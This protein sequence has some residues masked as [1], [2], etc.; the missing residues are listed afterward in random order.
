MVLS[1][2]R[3]PK[4]WR[5]GKQAAEADFYDLKGVLEGLWEQLPIAETLTL[6]PDPLPF[7]HPLISYRL[8][9]GGKTEVGWAGVLH[10]ETQEHYKSKYALL[11][12][13]LDLTLLLPHWMRHPD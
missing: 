2:L 7:L 9:L 3:H 11:V 1:G 6:H 10:P 13:E 12:A 8:H 4:H 5:P